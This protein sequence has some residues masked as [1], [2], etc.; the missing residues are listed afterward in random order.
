MHEFEDQVLNRPLLP[1]NA[2]PLHNLSDYSITFMPA[3]P[4]QA[5]WATDHLLAF[6]HLHQGTS[7]VNEEAILGV[8]PPVPNDGPPVI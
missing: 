2:E 1:W 3:R 4:Q 7:H 8:D 5:L 6:N